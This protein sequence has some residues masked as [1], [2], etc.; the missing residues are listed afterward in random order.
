MAR[1]FLLNHFW[2][3]PPSELRQVLNILNQDDLRLNNAVKLATIEARSREEA[4]CESKVY[5]TTV[6]PDDNEDTQ[7]DAF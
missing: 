4:K 5:A 3:G 2:A 6:A 1:F 7:I